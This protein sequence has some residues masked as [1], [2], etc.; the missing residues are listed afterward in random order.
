MS[1]IYPIYIIFLSKF[2]IITYLFEY[3]WYV[4]EIFKCWLKISFVCH[5]IF[6][7]C[8]I[9]IPQNFNFSKNSRSDC[10][11]I[12]EQNQFLNKILLWKITFNVFPPWSPI[13]RLTSQVTLFIDEVMECC[14]PYILSQVFLFT[15]KCSSP[16]PSVGGDILLVRS[17][18]S[19][20][21]INT[22]NIHTIFWTFHR[23]L[24]ILWRC[25]LNFIRFFHK[26]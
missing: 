3:L 17:R 4:K 15:S 24:H 22:R 6:R 12:F 14:A 25:S 18:F 9:Y 5:Y 23:H 1:L 2:V 26:L 16:R 13:W 21:Y 11:S 19:W 8:S 7:E 20:N 10:P